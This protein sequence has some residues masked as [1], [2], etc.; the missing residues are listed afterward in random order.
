LISDTAKWSSWFR[1]SSDVKSDIRALQADTSK[2]YQPN[3]TVSTLATIYDVSLKQNLLTNPVVRGDSTTYYYTPYQATSKLNVNFYNA[4]STNQSCYGVT[5]TVT[6]G[7]NVTFGQ[8]LYL[9]PDG[10]YWLAK[11]D[12]YATLPAT[13]MALASISGDA[14]GL[15]L[16]NGSVRFDSW[17]LSGAGGKTFVSA[18]TGGAITTT[19]PAT[20]T[21]QLQL[22][23][24]AR[25]ATTLNFNPSTDIAEV[26]AEPVTAP[27][28]L[29][30]GY[31]IHGTGT[32]TVDSANITWSA[33]LLDVN[34]NLD[35]SGK[36]INEIPHC[37][38]HTVDTVGYTLSLDRWVWANV[39]VSAMTD[40]ESYLIN[41]SS[42]DTIQYQDTRA[43]HLMI[44]ININGTTSNASDDLWLRIVNVTDGAIVDYDFRTSSGSGNYARWGVNSYDINCS[45][46]DK[47]VIQMRNKTNNND[48]TLYRVSI[49]F[50]LYHYE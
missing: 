38:F 1:D 10:K 7:E 11:A 43:C 35:I 8:V 15:T 40:K 45:P 14:T 23:G 26:G 48:L 19:A 41:I 9:K 12:N 5:E 27:N 50:R 34:G 37:Y 16:K 30:S 47:Y 31:L 21:N 39:D 13:R 29:V 36:I 6:V 25:S 42:G 32:S 4:L 22:I 3:D 28:A 33:G 17:S 44:D 24:E 49:L 2:Y 18:A 46:N 20:L